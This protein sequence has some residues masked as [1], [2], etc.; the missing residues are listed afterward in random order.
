MPTFKTVDTG[1]AEMQSFLCTILDVRC[2]MVNV[3][4]VALLCFHRPQNP[5]VVYIVHRTSNIV[6]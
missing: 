3:N 6:H 2:T 5:L 1:T 4:V